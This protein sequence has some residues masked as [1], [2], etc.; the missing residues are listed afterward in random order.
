MLFGLGILLKEG[1]AF[2]SYLMVDVSACP[3]NNIKIAVA[4]FRALFI[5]TQTKYIFKFFK[6]YIRNCNTG[7]R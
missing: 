3:E 4:V 5:V 1:L 2:I 6:A 7:S